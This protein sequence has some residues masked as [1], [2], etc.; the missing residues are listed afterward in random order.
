MS[1]ICVVR[2]GQASFGSDNYDQLSGLGWQQARWL[3][4]HWAKEGLQFDRVVSGNLL[5]HRQTVQGICEGL[6]LDY[7]GAQELPQL[8]EFDFKRVMSAYAEKNPRAAPH[9]RAVREDYYRF[10][11]MALHAWSSGEIEATESWQQFEQRI[12]E[13]LAVLALGGKGGRTLVVSSGGAIA[14]MVRQTLGASSLCMPQLNM[15]IKNTAVSHFFA[16]RSGTTLH[17]FNHV[18]HLDYRERREFITYS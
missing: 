5:R 12:E 1:E 8:N 14:M 11:K 10:L 7:Q 15:Q 6:G 2:H 16:G 18:P 3:G 17:S 9:S 13:V 4:E